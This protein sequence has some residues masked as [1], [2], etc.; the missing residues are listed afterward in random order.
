MPSMILKEAPVYE[1]NQT[2]SVLLAG[3]LM[4]HEIKCMKEVYDNTAKSS[5]IPLVVKR[6]APVQKFKIP[7]KNLTPNSCT[8][9]EFMFI[10][11]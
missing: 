6:N 9:V 10:K 11:S 3:K 8:D 1:P 5:F 7:F 2:Y 4:N